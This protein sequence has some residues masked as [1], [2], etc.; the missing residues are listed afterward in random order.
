MRAQGAIVEEA[1]EYDDDEKKGRDER[2]D[3]RVGDDGDDDEPSEKGGGRGGAD[4]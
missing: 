4:A 3:V 1:L 2:V